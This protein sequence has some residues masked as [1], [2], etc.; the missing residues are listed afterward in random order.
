M[1]LLTSP[2]LPDPPPTSAGPIPSWDSA[3]GDG[4]ATP[5]DVG[6]L[7]P[8]AAQNL[9]KIMYAARMA[10]LDLLRAVSFLAAQITKW[11]PRCDRLLDRLVCYIWSS[12][13]LRQVA[14]CNDPVAALSVHLYADADFAGCPDTPP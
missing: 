2:F 1:N 4:S 13:S 9:M 10:R 12:L 5:A 7:Q 8:I 14:W 11:S 6:Q 3:L